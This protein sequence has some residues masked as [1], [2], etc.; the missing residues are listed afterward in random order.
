[1]KRFSFIVCALAWAGCSSDGGGGGASGSAGT[2][3]S[4][5]SSGSSGTGGGTNLDIHCENIASGPD[6]TCI[7]DTNDV[8][9]P[10]EGI[11]ECS[12]ASTGPA[13]CCEDLTYPDTGVCQCVQVGCFESDT[14]CRCSASEA[15]QPLTACQNA[16]PYCCATL[17][18]GAIE[19][20]T[21]SNL[22]LGCDGPNQQTV[23]SCSLDI[24]SCSGSKLPT[25]DCK[26]P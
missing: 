7:Q 8:W 18:D 13:L 16:W 12:A 26:S 11:P 15:G 5:G 9:E 1:M 4:A 23:T 22:D 19:S 2:S 24:M 10:S 25:D 21:C 6:C 3:G 20:C 17:F 14:T